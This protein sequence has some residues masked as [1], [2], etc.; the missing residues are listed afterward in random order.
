VG[1]D[2]RLTAEQIAAL[3]PGDAVVIKSG[4]EF[5]RP[6][7]AAGTVIRVGA[8][9]VDVCCDGHKGARYVERYR[10]RDGLREGTGRPEL[11]QADAGH[12]AARRVAGRETRHIEA[13]YRHWHRRPGDLEALLELRDAIS[14]HLD[15]ALVT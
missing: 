14:E 12:R 1:L 10:L 4:Q 15:E 2:N 13:L 11:V 9:H 6:R 7:Y 8:S 3:A 5:N